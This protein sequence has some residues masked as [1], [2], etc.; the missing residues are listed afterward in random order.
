[1]IKLLMKEAFTPIY[2]SHCRKD[3]RVDGHPFNADGPSSNN[4]LYE[5]QISFE[6]VLIYSS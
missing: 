3:K 6:S 1:M 4:I 5:H 2:I